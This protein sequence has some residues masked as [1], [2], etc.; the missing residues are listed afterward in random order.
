MGRN[1]E[2]ALDSFSSLFVGAPDNLPETFP[3]LNAVLQTPRCFC[4]TYLVVA[5]AV[6]GVAAAVAVAAVLVIDSC[7]GES[8]RCR[9]FFVVGC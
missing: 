7:V 2:A 6:E 8:Y 5:P 4:L 3:T 9:S 1:R